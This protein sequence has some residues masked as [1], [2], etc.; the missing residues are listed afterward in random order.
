MYTAEDF[1]DLPTLQIE[2][3]VTVEC[4]ISPPPLLPSPPFSPPPPP[5]PP[6]SRSPSRPPPPSLSSPTPLSVAYY[7]RIDNVA[8]AG[9]IGAGTAAGVLLA[10]AARVLYRRASAA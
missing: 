6:S 2:G 9:Y 5:P 8:M 10:V 3:D 1:S 4:D 7:R